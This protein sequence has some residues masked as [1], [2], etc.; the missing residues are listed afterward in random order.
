MAFLVEI[1]SRA[2]RD[3]GQLYRQIDAEYSG[4]A[5]KWYRG[6]KEA[7]QSARTAEPMPGDAQEG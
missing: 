2:E 7:I 4:A 5:L 6:L 1:T 3:L